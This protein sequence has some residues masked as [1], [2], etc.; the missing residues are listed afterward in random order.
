MLKWWRP[1]S[2]PNRVSQIEGLPIRVVLL[3][4]LGTSFSQSVV[5]ECKKDVR[6]IEKWGWDEGKRKEWRENFP[7]QVWTKITWIRDRAIL[8]RAGHF[9]LTKIHHHAGHQCTSLYLLLVSLRTH[10]YLDIVPR[11]PC[12]VTSLT[13]H[14]GTLELTELVVLASVC[15]SGCRD[16]KKNRNRTKRNREQPDHRSRLPR[17]GALS[18]AGC[19]TF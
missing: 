19:L 2:G 7:S 9:N 6:H 1:W 8:L 5:C 4:S 16:R 10:W 18:V 11:L 3:F 12:N 15:R 13:G 17:L 14:L